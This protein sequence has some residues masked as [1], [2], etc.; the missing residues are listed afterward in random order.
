VAGMWRLTRSRERATVT[1]EL[2]GPERERDALTAEAGRVLA[3]AAPG[4]AHE[5]RFAT[6]AEAPVKS[7]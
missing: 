7:R 5:V 6:L 1:I 3:F 4:A 2:F